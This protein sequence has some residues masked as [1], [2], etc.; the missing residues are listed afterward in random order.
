[1]EEEEDEANKRPGGTWK[2]KNTPGYLPSAAPRG[3]QPRM[4]RG[5][6]HIAIHSAGRKHSCQRNPLIRNYLVIYVIKR[7]RRSR[8]KAIKWGPSRKPGPG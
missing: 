2:Y 1:M 4:G 6:V 8:N 3:V 5:G 7:R